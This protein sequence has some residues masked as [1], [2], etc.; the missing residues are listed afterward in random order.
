MP[1]SGVQETAGDGADPG[2]ADRGEGERLQGQDAAVGLDPEHPVGSGE[3]CPGSGEEPVYLV[4]ALGGIDVGPQGMG[5]EPYQGCPLAGPSSPGPATL[6]TP[7]LGAIPLHQPG[8]REA[9]PEPMA[10]ALVHRQAAPGTDEEVQGKLEEVPPIGESET[11]GGGLDLL[12]P[13]VADG[14]QA[15][16]L[17]VVEPLGPAPEFPDQEHAGQGQWPVG[18]AEAIPGD[19]PPVVVEHPHEVLPLGRQV[20]G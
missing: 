8:A 20:L 10:D 2:P 5:Q 6:T 19:I 7:H 17:Q 18:P 11:L 9:G 15:H 12:Q 3:G 1:R 13:R 4:F 16:G 14:H